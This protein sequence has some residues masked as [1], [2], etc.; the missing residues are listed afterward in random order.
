MPPDAPAGPVRLHHP[1][2]REDVEKVRHW[3]TTAVGVPGFIGFAVG[4]TAFWDPLV[5]SS[6]NRITCNNIIDFHITNT[7]L[8]YFNLCSGI[9]KANEEVGP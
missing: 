4:R 7:L 6:V 3:L 8:F 9:W 5:D 1:G 2:S